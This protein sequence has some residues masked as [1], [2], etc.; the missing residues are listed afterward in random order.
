MRLHLLPALLLPLA[1]PALAHASFHLWYPDEVF[2]DATGTVQ[3]VEFSDS[4]DFEQFLTETSLT[5]KTTAYPCATDLPSSSTAGKHFLVASQGYAALAGAPTADY[6]L[7]NNF[8][9]TSSD[10]VY[11]A[12]TIEPH[13]SFN[14]NLP[15]D[16]THSLSFNGFTYT[17]ITN[18]PT[19]FAGATGSI[20]AAPEPASL[21]LLALGGL[22]LVK[23]RR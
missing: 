11:L 1:L 21:S 15:L 19:N 22:L 5:T 8:L 4:S 13:F 7:P 12:G 18:S 16:G 6:L 10:T 17:S 14:G 9:S 2:S 3:F 23:R 20:T